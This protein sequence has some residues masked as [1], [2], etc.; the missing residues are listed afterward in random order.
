MTESLHEQ[1]L[2]EIGRLKIAE[3]NKICKLCQ[4]IDFNA[5]W[6]PKRL[7]DEERAARCLRLGPDLEIA[8]RARKCIFCRWLHEDVLLNTG[9]E[10]L[11]EAA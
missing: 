8:M 3:A 1:D 9:V 11:P 2:S 4:T 7:T 10:R 6:S 5:L